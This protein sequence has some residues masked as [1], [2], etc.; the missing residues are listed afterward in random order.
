MPIPSYQSCMLPLLKILVKGQTF[1]LKGAIETLSEQFELTLDEI[2]QLLPSQ[3]QGVFENRVAWA[4]TYL[5]Q[6]GLIEYPKR[7]QMRITDEGKRVI[8]SGIENIDT[9]FLKQYPSF[10]T[11]LARTKSMDDQSLDQ[12][13]PEDLDELLLEFADIANEWFAKRTFV[14]S[15]WK[16]INNFFKSENLKNA[17]W[18]EIQKLGDHIH[19]LGTNALA[20]ARAFGN[21]NYPIQQYRDSFLKIAHGEGSVEER[22]RWFLTDDSATSKYLGAS[23]VGEFFGQLYADNHVFF[24][25]RDEEAAEYLGIDPGFQRGD[26]AARRFARFNQAIQPIF[27]SYSRIVGKRTDVPIGL[28]VDQFFSWLYETKELGKRIQQKHNTKTVWEFAPGAG[29]VYW[30]DFY[31]DGVAAIGWNEVSDLHK[32]KTRE[33]ISAAIKREKNPSTEPRNDSLAMWQWYK[34]VKP[35]DTILA[36]KGRRT[37]IGVGIVMSGYEYRPTRTDYHHVRQVKWE[38]K[39]IWNLPQGM[40]LTMKALT[41]LTPYPDHVAKLM[42]IIGEPTPPPSKKRYWWVNC[43][44][45]RWDVANAP[46]GHRERFVSINESGTK[47]RIFKYFEEIDVGDEILAYVSSPI[48]RV[49]TLLNVTKALDEDEYFECEIVQQFDVQPQWEEL[50]KDEQLSECEPL[51][52][53][54][55]TLFS[56]TDDEFIEIRELTEGILPPIKPPYLIEDA[57]KDL[58]MDENIFRGILDL[59]QSKRNVILQG[60]PGV[61]KTYISKRIA[62]SLMAEKDEGRVR[63]VQFHQSYSYEDFVQGLRPNLSGGFVLK[64]GIFYQFCERARNDDRPY[65]FIIDEINRGNLSKI[66]GELMM[67]IENDKRSP[68]YAIPLV[69]QEESDIDFYVP[70]N[71]YIIGLMNTAD[72]SLAMVDYALRRR[73]SFFDLVP[74]YGKDKLNQRLSE[75]CGDGLCQ[76]ITEAFL[77]LNR[78]IAADTDNLGPGFLI[79]HSYFCL[80]KT[81][82]LDGPGYR[83]I[84]DTEIAPLLREYWFDQPKVA[85]DWME[86]LTAIAG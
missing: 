83:R 51:L 78:K 11:F 19:S 9:N 27:E 3:R 58:F 23:S 15:Y 35:G 42:S 75:I 52:N 12:I 76:R 38:K 57:V 2:A 14:V 26:D 60:P 84:I 80:E 25:K 59:L 45:S 56:L 44:P 72:R 6:A 29:A 31:S 18:S 65:V 32:F 85:Q 4:K 73:F 33:E 66:L 50:K 40:N 81:A 20:R 34:E 5:K 70:P 49:T 61:G 63:M 82:L 79:G 71:V 48:R 8:K 1:S 10:Q 13:N 53:N 21:E 69:Y 47:C 41:N 30:D 39:G 16:F 55:G 68:Q 86:R 46:I 62:F 77:E 24:N 28:E 37:I 22:M 74:A 64:N 67:L 36:K 17:E 54:Q 7:G 43:N